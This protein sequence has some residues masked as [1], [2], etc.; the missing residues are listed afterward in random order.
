MAEAGWKGPFSAGPGPYETM[1][2]RF[3][4]GGW[5]DGAMAVSVDEGKGVWAAP[6]G[7]DPDD[8]VSALP[9]GDGHDVF[10]GAGQWDGYWGTL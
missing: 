3:N 2:G 6:I 4:G 8:G 1:E 9:V 7:T 5:V 10:M